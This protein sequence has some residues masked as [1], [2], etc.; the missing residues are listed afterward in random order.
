VDANHR[1]ELI[2]DVRAGLTTRGQKS[3]PAK[4]FYDDIGSALFETI[5]LLPEYGLTRAEMRLLDRHAGEIAERLDRQP[6]IA[7]LGAG[8]GK[9][10]ARLLE[11]L[12]RRSGMAPVTYYAIDVSAGALAQCEREIARVPG[13]RF[14]GLTS[15]YAEGLAEVSRSRRRDEQLAVF[16]LGSTIGNFERQPALAFLRQLRALLEPRDRFV[17]ATDLVKPETVLVPAYD[18]SVGVTAAF[19]RNLLARINRELDADFDLEQFRH[20]VKWND[21]ERRVE[22]HLRALSNQ[23]VRVRAAHVEFSLLAGE[24]I[25]TESSHKYTLDD[26]DALAAD[27]AFEREAQWTDPTWPFAQTLLA[28]CGSTLAGG[29]RE[30]TRQ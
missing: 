19:N 11:A 30:W 3:L 15:T 25:W 22:M 17:L 27:A 1:V 16:F 10:M 20:L 4:W 23:Q 21:A 24:T 26:L 28:P 8:S 14:V 2:A 6:I 7:E 12:V 18:D 9:K 5:C 29:S 13:V